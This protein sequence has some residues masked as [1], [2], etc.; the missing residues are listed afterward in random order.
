MVCHRLTLHWSDVLTHEKN[1]LP[2][3]NCGNELKGTPDNLYERIWLVSFADLSQPLALNSGW[4]A[5][6]SAYALSVLFQR[7]NVGSCSA[8]SW[9]NRREC[10]NG[11]P[12]S[13]P[14][15][16]ESS[17]LAWSLLAKFFLWFSVLFWSGC[18]S[19]QGIDEWCFP[20]SLGFYLITARCFE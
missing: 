9:D 4:I 8:W 16:Y 15:W 17:R 13:L 7:N 20:S 19:S 18:N 2:Q 14:V 3:T 11:Y 12:D 10:R 6:Q 1:S 5:F